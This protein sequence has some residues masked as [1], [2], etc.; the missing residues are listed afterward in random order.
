MFVFGWGKEVLRSSN[1]DRYFNDI[2][3]E[4]DRD[5]LFDF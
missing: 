2:D 4:N 5:P 3:L 1:W